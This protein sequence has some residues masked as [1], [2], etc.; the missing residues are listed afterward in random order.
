MLRQHRWI[1]HNS[2]CLPVIKTPYLICLLYWRPIVST[3]EKV[4]NIFLLFASFNLRKIRSSFVHRSTHCFIRRQVF[5]CIQVVIGNNRATMVQTDH[6][7][8]VA[9]LIYLFHA[10]SCYLQPSSS[11]LEDSEAIEKGLTAFLTTFKIL[12]SCATFSLLQL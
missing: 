3:T 2:Q 10:S 1:N 7:Y 12:L 11:E 6:F 5:V 4:N 9:L 8:L